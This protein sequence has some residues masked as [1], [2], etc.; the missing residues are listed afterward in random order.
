MEPIYV[1][2]HKNPDTDS[3][4]S[5]IA[6]AAL[7]NALGE[8]NYI[9]A[10]LGHL[11]TESTFL[12]ERF[13]FA[14]P[15]YLTSVRTQISDIE[16]DQPPKVASSMSA[17]YA[18]EMLHGTANGFSAIPVTREDG[19]LYGLITAR[20]VA[21]NDMDSINRSR[22]DQVPVYN[23]LSALEGLIL[24]SEEDMFEE[25]S[26]EV[27]ISLP[28]TASDAIRE[29]CVV[30]CGDQSEIV[31][32]ALSV[33]ASCVILCQ[34]NLSD[35]YRG[36][37]SKTCII[38][39]PCDAYRAARMLYQSIP[40]DR[41]VRNEKIVYFHL[42]EYLDDVQE[43]VLQSR[44]RAYPILDE[45]DR[46]VGT[47]SRYHL[48]R[49]RKKKVVL[50]DH[51]EK[52]QSVAGLEQ[53]EIVAIL[54]HHRLADVQTGNP[55]FMRNEPVGSTTSIVASMYQEKGLMPGPAL[56]GLMAAAII[57]DTVMFK[58]PT[59]TPHDKKLAERLA[60]Y[61]GVDL[62]E[63]GQAMFARGASADIPVK[64][65]LKSDMKEYH[66]S[67]HSLAIS[68]VTTVNAESFLNRKAEIIT[69]LTNLQKENHYDMT[70]LMLT[71]VLK[72]GT[73]LL[74]CGDP[75]I[76][77]VAF[78]VEDIQDHYVFLPKV[79]SRKKQIVPSLSQLWG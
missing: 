33:G 28:G 48:I 13:G 36:K 66:L 30:I 58:S 68:Q 29:G 27:I 40:V 12:L 14:P 74:F 41:I 53:A 67:N 71:N 79:M 51:N 50:V 25:I 7:K 1:F 34:S 56:A 69:G 39:T 32:K 35:Q 22:I 59:C 6:Y 54:D 64:D 3:I 31:E 63:L 45:A 23:I 77:R 21:E 52:S 62:E 65:L 49:P 10:R 78:G 47:L 57:S 11:N 44:F 46:V 24:N 76:I 61:A 18:W 37:S 8:N 19:T 4:V 73:E 70:M 55:V 72:E 15:L 17:Y 60:R 38:A 43:T 5:A 42:N 2:G 16:Y 9:A 26:G 75:D 20:S